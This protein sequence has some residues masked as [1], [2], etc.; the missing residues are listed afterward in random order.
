[1]LNILIVSYFD[2]KINVKKAFFKKKRI[3]FKRGKEKLQ[4][5][6]LKKFKFLIFLT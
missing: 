5:I 1:M 2:K 3:I 4:K 6:K